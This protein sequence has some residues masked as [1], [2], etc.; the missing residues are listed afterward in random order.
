MLVV[1]QMT[2][3]QEASCHAGGQADDRIAGGLPDGPYPC[4]HQRRQV[5]AWA[6][7]VRRGVAQPYLLHYSSPAK[8]CQGCSLCPGQE[9]VDMCKGCPVVW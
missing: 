2:G 7:G 3:L 5:S 1:R 4:A 8:A 6:G 9:E